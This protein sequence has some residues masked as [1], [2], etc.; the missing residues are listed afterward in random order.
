MDGREDPPWCEEG[1]VAL[2]PPIKDVEVDGRLPFL[3]DEGG[4]GRSLCFEDDAG[5]G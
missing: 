4:R 1:R 3:R 5:G 2:S